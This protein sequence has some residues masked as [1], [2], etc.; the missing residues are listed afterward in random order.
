MMDDPKPLVDQELLTVNA[1]AIYAQFVQCAIEIYI[2][3]A[4][5]MCVVRC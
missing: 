2:L 4:F 3:H 5:D 1:D